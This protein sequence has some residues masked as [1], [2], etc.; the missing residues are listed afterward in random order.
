MTQ[1]S[2]TTCGIHDSHSINTCHFNLENKMSN[3]QF[4]AMFL[5]HF[6]FISFEIIFLALHV[7]RHY[8]IPIYLYYNHS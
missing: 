2:H 3:N 4:S 1:Y 8:I 5:L 6:I 7:R